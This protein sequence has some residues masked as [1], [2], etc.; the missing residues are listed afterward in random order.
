[1][2]KQE[3]LRS[4]SDIYRFF[5]KN[6][7]PIY[8]VSPTAYNILGLGQWIQG[9]KYITHFDSFDGGHFRVTNPAQNTEREFQSMEDMVNYLLSHKE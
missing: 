1:M 6:T 2:S 4:L 9:F 8:F 3:P 7:T 5:R